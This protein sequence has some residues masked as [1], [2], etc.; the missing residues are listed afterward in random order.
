MRVLAKH[1]PADY[2][3]LWYQRLCPAA[4]STAS[5]CVGKPPLH[6]ALLPIAVRGAGGGL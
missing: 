4:P 2:L 6:E 1:R 3:D 5:A